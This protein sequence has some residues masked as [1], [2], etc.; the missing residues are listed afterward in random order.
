MESNEKETGV[1]YDLT[2]I[3]NYYKNK[4]S[5]NA[6]IFNKKVYKFFFKPFSIIL[7][8]SPL[9]IILLN[10]NKL[11]TKIFPVYILAYTLTLI[12]AGLVSLFVIINPY[13]KMRVNA[14]FDTKEKWFH[15]IFSFWSAKDVRNYQKIELLKY[16]EEKEIIELPQYELLSKAIDTKIEKNKPSSIIKFGVLATI[17]VPL[18]LQINQ[19]IIK[20]VDDID[21]LFAWGLVLTFLVISVWCFINQVLGLYDIMYTENRSNEQL[22]NLVKEI[23]FDM[24]MKK[25]ALSDV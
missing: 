8:L 23:I 1:T 2:E 25:H 3:L 11:G 4:L 17:L 24:K 15:D 10:L 6:F 21:T 18:W 14:L 9:L 20:K 19:Q 5:F 7:V 22:N 12:I 13:T 16:F